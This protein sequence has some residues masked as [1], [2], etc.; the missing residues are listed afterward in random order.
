MKFLCQF[1]PCQFQSS[2]YR[3]LLR[4]TWDKHALL[5]NFKYHCKISDCPRTYT[6][7]QSFRRHVKSH[8]SWF[9]DSHLKEKEGL[10][11]DETNDEVE[12][13]DDDVDAEGDQDDNHV[14]EESTASKDS[15]DIQMGYAGISMA[16]RMKMKTP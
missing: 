10:D 11:L 3:R 8:H 15:K 13:A 2:S 12:G 14:D 9:Y 4:H 16:A 6:N 1:E 5:P 7:S